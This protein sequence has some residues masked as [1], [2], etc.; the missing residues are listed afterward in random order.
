MI[1]PGNAQLRVSLGQRVKGGASIIAIIHPGLD[2]PSHDV[3][4]ESFA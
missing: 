4:A 3:L 1:L 2:E